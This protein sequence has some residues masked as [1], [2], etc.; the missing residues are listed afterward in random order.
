MDLHYKVNFHE[1]LEALLSAIMAEKNRFRKFKNDETQ[2][3]NILL[4]QT[5]TEIAEH[6]LRYYR[7]VNKVSVVLVTVRV[8]PVA[9]SY[10]VSVPNL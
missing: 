9:C 7:V 1:L 2:I 5:L 6:V 8:R 3:G 10:A 4:K